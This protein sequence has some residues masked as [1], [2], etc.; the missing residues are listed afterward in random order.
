MKGD[1]MKDLT[2]CKCGCSKEITIKPHHN[3]Y[4]TPDYIRGHGG[5][6]LE[7]R[8]KQSASQKKRYEDPKEREKIALATKIACN[9]PEMRKKKSEAAKKAFNTPE[10][11]KR[12]S[13]IS[14]EWQSR[15]DMKKKMCAVQ[16]IA[17]NR[18]ATKLKHSRTATIV[19]NRLD[20]R[21]DQSKFMKDSMQNEQY[22]QKFIAAMNR[23]EVKKKH[24]LKQ[25]ENWNS[26]EYVQK[27]MAAR[28]VSQNNREKELEAILH[29][30]LPNEY[31]FVGD[32]KV[33]IAGKCPDFINING[34]KKIIELFGDYWHKDDNPEDRMH[35]FKPFGFDTLVIWEHELKNADRLKS[36]IYKFHGKEACK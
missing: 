11:R 31:K 28:N 33:I 24:S 2:L 7:A 20:K 4:G 19:N 5:H 36:R 13:L 8:K 1:N 9:T 12:R 21:M 10:I 27:Q 26:P 30:I 22:K 16:K 35:I 6:T 29:S 14:K 25:I 23:P 15:P 32:G 3:W 34:Q 18:P 17:Q